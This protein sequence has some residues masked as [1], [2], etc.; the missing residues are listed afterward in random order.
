MMPASLPEVDAEA[1]FRRV[2][3][4]HG[5]HRYAEATA[6]AMWALLVAPTCVPALAYLRDA[7]RSADEFGKAL[8]FARVVAMLQPLSAAAHA[9]VAL[10]RARMPDHM[11]T[12]EASRRALCLDPTNASVEL[13]LGIAENNLG[14]ISAAEIHLGH[15]L[16]LR[17]DWDLAWLSYAAVSF[18]MAQYNRAN[19]AAKKALEF[20]ANAAEA[21]MWIGR[22]ALGFQDVDAANRHF[23]A[24][25]QLDAGRALQ[26]RIANLTMT[27]S[28]LFDE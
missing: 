10:C 12:A 28:T 13:Y 22:S 6:N 7:S 1:L 21:H 17:L 19:T 20:G 24:A 15:A 4:L 11:A 25:V 8:R 23:N 26:T 14:Q 3:R 5:E 27:R 2:L 16:T 9:L 18:N